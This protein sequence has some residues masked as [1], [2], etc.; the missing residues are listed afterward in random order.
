MVTKVSKQDFVLN[1]KL[2]L[3]SFITNLIVLLLFVLA[4][5]DNIFISEKLLVSNFIE[6]L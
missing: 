4:K 6:S 3:S 1:Y 5:K 2:N